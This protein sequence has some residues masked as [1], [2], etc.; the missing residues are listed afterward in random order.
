M[1]ESYRAGLRCPTCPSLES[2]VLDS[3]G[4]Q[5]G[6]RIRRRRRCCHCG[7][8]FTSYERTQAAVM[9]EAEAHAT[10]RQAKAVLA[11]LAAAN[12]RAA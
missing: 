12:P 4:V 11:R 10:I 2:D 9:T 5:D 3:R 7:T 1:T 8:L 6:S